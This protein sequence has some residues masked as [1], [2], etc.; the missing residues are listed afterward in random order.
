MKRVRS[1]LHNCAAQLDA[2]MSYSRRSKFIYFILLLQTKFIAD[3]VVELE[4]T[5]TSVPYLFDKFVSRVIFVI[6]MLI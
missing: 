6:S 1:I 2:I 3:F 4:I 5:N